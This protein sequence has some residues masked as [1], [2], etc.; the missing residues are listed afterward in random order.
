MNNEDTENT[1]CKVM[2]N[3]EGQ[4]SIWDADRPN[5]DGWRDAP[6]NG[7]KSECLAYIKEAWTDMRPISLRNK[8]NNPASVHELSGVHMNGN[9]LKASEK[10][11]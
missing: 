3:D 5:P 11:S 1:K 7:S 8:M 9:H 2:V 6:M 4:Y 10:K